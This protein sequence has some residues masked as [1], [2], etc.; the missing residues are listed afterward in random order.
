MPVTRG[1]PQSE[2][3]VVVRSWV[4][5][6]KPVTL[7]RHTVSVATPYRG[8]RCR[9]RPTTLGVRAHNRADV[10]HRRGRRRVPA[11]RN[12]A[13]SKPAISASATRSRT[14]PGKS[15]N[16][17]A[18][19]RAMVAAVPSETRNGSIRVDTDAVA[20]LPYRIDTVVDYRGAKEKG[21]Q[22]LGTTD[23]SG[24]RRWPNWPPSPLPATCTSPSPQRTHSP[25]CATPIR[26]DPRTHRAAPPRSRLNHPRPTSAHA[27]G[28]VV[29]AG[30][31]GS[32]WRRAGPW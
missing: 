17:S 26:Q 29:P 28:C 25:P 19:R 16:P 1:H 21:V 12:P 31:G 22:S 27:A 5:W 20:G 30:C 13:S 14:R 23:A 18:A 15:S 2:S 7:A 24:P 32:R 4:R 10:R 11:T 3:A 6:C 8:T 9:R